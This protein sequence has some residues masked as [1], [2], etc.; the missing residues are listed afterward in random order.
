MKL[1]IGAVLLGVLCSA[2]PAAA[3]SGILVYGS[4]AST[5]FT[6]ADSF[7]A[8]SGTA[9]HPGFGG[10]IVEN[11]LWRGLFVDIG[12]FQTT[13][14]GERVFLDSG[15]VYKLGIP[16]QVKVTPIDLVGGWRV[17]KDR[18][19]TFLGAGVSSVSYKETGDFSEGDDNVSQRKVGPVL[20]GGVDVAL[21]KWV[22]VGAEIRYRAIKG[23]L[24]SGGVSEVYG[25][26]EL[27]GVSAAMRMSVGR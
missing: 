4:Y 25:E 13:V 24:G 26:K 7:K 19:S 20:L 15:T 6:A 5:A 9:R 2:A 14:K 1:R 10:G 3:Q 27:G 22:Q 21:T 23:V 18:L 12:M 17:T 11:R 8:V 16:L